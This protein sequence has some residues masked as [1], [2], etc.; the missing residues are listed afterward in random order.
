MTQVQKAVSSLLSYAAKQKSDREKEGKTLFLE[1]EEEFLWLVVA[2]K[3]MTPVLSLK[4]Q[5]VYVLCLRCQAFHSPATHATSPLAHP[6]IDPRVQP[7][8]LITKDPQR[9]YKDLLAAQNINFISRV[10]DVTKLK[11]KW[12]P[13]EA[14]RQLA[15]EY[16]LFLADERVVPLLPKLLGK[17][18]FQ[19]KKWVSVRSYFHC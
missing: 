12:A 19:K 1:G 17:V 6:I 14:R 2:T 9:F 18:F 4:P 7:I 15:G 3:V 8:C 5:R 16:G 11:G 13:F 10:V